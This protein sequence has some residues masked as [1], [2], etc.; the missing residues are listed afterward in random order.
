MRALTG[1]TASYDSDGTPAQFSAGSGTVARK[2]A[3]AG[4]VYSSG[5]AA[6]GNLLL[7][8]AWDGATW[9]AGGNTTSDNRYAYVAG[10]A[11]A[12]PIVLVNQR[13]TYTLAAATPVQTD[14]NLFGSVASGS[15]AVDFFTGTR[16]SLGTLSLDLDLP[17]ASGAGTTSTRYSLD[18]IL[19]GDG[20]T[21]AG[22]VSV[23][24]ATCA[25]GTDVCGTGSAQGFFAS[26][27][28]GKVGLTFQAYS[29]GV[30]NFG[31]ALA[32]TE[33]GTRGAIPSS[34]GVRSTDYITSVA[35]N[36]ALFVPMQRTTQV[37]GDRVTFSG[38]E[39]IESKP[40][41]SDAN[42]AKTG[43]V[44]ASSAG[45]GGIGVPGSTDFIGWGSWEAGTVNGIAGVPNI[46]NAHYIVATPTTDASMPTAGTASYTLAG[47]SAPV[48]SGRATGTLDSGSLTANFST[49]RIGALMSLTF[50]GT[51]FNVGG[52]G[53]F[54]QAGSPAAVIVPGTGSNGA[55]YAAVLNG[56][57]SG[58][59]AARAGITYNVNL[60]VGNVNG[61]AVFQKAP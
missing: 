13:A 24:G 2:G 27:S 7:L 23:G 40:R 53:L 42:F 54:R 45:A 16:N 19:S 49:G 30:G 55:P 4:I 32:F 18:G 12:P 26:A 58:A 37:E 44:T 50:G 21:L 59:G 3:Q 15:L 5:T 25:A 41:G 35:Y 9:T 6:A 33:A 52:T 14:R 56:V 29:S 28:G 8:G 57:F 36:T 51:T 1:A 60:P 39:L 17:R 47:G 10:V 43:T 20:A 38:A 61:A 46:S 11:V 48:S 34:S 31:G 22:A